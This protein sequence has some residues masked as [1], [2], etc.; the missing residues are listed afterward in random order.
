MTQQAPL[1]GLSVEDVMNAV[2]SQLP[3]GEGWQGLA[4]AVEV[5]GQPPDAPSRICEIARAI[6]AD[7]TGREL[8]EH[9]MDVTIRQYTWTADLMDGGDQTA[10]QHSIM[11]NGQNSVIAYLIGLIARAEE[12]E[13]EEKRDDD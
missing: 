1:Q 6:F 3:G 7:G 4:N 9:L 2:G 11:R 10:L 8:L 5:A 13:A 12:I